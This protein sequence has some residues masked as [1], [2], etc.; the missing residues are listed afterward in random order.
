MLAPVGS[1]LS[2]C[3]IRAPPP[4]EDG[5]RTQ[6]LSAS[7]D[8]DD[9]FPSGG[10][11]P[12]MAS[13]LNKMPLVD[14][15][16]CG[17]DAMVL[18]VRQPSIQSSENEGKIGDHIIAAAPDFVLRKGKKDPSGVKPVAPGGVSETL[19]LPLCPT[20]SIDPALSLPGGIVSDIAQSSPAESSILMLARN[21]RTPTDTELSV[22]LVPEF[23]PVP[24]EDGWKRVQSSSNN[25]NGSIVARNNSLA[26]TAM[27]V[28]LNLIPNLILS[29]PLNHGIAFQN[30]N[31]NMASRPAGRPV[32][33]HTSKRF[34]TRG[35]SLTAADLPANNKKQLTRKSPRLNPWLLRPAVVPLNPLT[36][37]HLLPPIQVAV[38][39]SGGLHYFKLNSIL[40]V[41]EE[42]IIAAGENVEYDE[43]VT[44]FF[45][46]YGYAEGCSMC[47]ILAIGICTGGVNQRLKEFAS[48]AVNTRA[49]SPK[50]TPAIHSSNGLM[51]DTVQGS[52]PL[53]PQGYAFQSSALLD[54]IVKVT[55]RLLRPV[56]HKPLVV[57]T[58]GR[59]VLSKWKS[60]KRL[61][62]AK[63]ELLL[64][65]TT[66]A[67]MLNSLTSLAELMKNWFK[68]AIESVP[69]K[70]RAQS[71]MMD[72]DNRSRQNLSI[73]DAFARQ[74]HL[75]D[76]SGV[77][78]GQLAPAEAER[79][80]KLTEE[81][82]IHSIYRLVSRTRQL[83]QL[84]GL[85]LRA[86]RAT[87]LPE[88]EWG[89][90]HGLTV[91]QLVQTR[92]GQD[93]IEKMLNNLVTS[94]ADYN[95]GLAEP[96]AEADQLASEFADQC[97]LF[98]SPGSRYAYLGFS[99]G[100]RALVCAEGSVRRLEYTA[101]ATKHFQ[102]A[103][104]HWHS[105]N[106][107]TGRTLNTRSQV[108]YKE[109]SKAAYEGGSPVAKAVSILADLGEADAIVD[110][111]LI[112]AANFETAPL[113]AMVAVEQGQSRAFAWENDL[114]H[115]RQ[116][117]QQESSS[118]LEGAGSTP[119]SPSSR[120]LTMGTS[121]TAKDAITTCWFLI[122]YHLT[123]ILQR[124]ELRKLGE[125]MVSRC[126]SERSE[127]FLH[128]FFSHL[129]QSGNTAT[130]L[131]IASPDVE[132][133]LQR[134]V[135][136]QDLLYKYYCIQKEFTKAGNLSLSRA[137]DDRERLSL[138]DR[139]KW[140]SN[141]IAV[142]SA[143]SP[144]RGGAWANRGGSQIE[145]EARDFLD[146]A[147]LQLRVLQASSEADLSPSEYEQLSSSLMKASDLFH[148]ADEHCHYDICLLVMHTCKENNPP[149]IE[150]LWRQIFCSTIFPCSTRD[151]G[152][153]TF[154]SDYQSDFS[155]D[156]LVTFFDRNSESDDSIPLFEDGNWRMKLET[157]VLS[158]GRELYGKGADF[159]FPV[160]FIYSELESKFARFHVISS[161]LL[162]HLTHVIEGLR[163]VYTEVVSGQENI[164]S[165][166]WPMQILTGVGVRYIEVMDAI[167]I[168]DA[169]EQQ[170]GLLGR[171]EH[172]RLEHLSGIVF[173]LEDWVRTAV[174][175][176]E[177]KQ[178]VRFLTLVRRV[179]E[180]L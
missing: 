80:A 68:Q 130:L 166:A 169:Q 133:W 15:S 5:A 49:Y 73:T 36:L 75:R 111:C 139:I 33:Y 106:L 16:F 45:T 160:Q 12:K 110:V 11:A 53:L 136:D 87:G 7:L 164:M 170:I 167:E 70:L 108:G 47:V 173:L 65:D 9:V 64:D 83:L 82:K 157:K 88:V 89:S 50:L 153:Y 77:T 163:R 152:L 124:P 162:C 175:V 122:F 119:V 121:V 17:G 44:R 126:V 27:T 114:Y 30:P 38:I 116:Q 22:G 8:Q 85:L 20:A 21:S 23:V 154:L 180:S 32:K 24:E 118:A 176:S 48:R 145:T 105:A 90:M 13:T 60:Q 168:V 39:N 37:Q 10:F 107:V 84:F 104:K 74:S 171:G 137:K 178:Q 96:S 43:K 63:L 151:N 1:K 71:N 143:G 148:F 141:A 155:T 172:L 158:L 41:F 94:T 61:T 67:Q 100:R 25:I 149:Y 134:E 81:R 26:S 92:D 2:L 40:S 78:N 99:M 135:Q 19:S 131:Q 101:M 150:N 147:K 52:D 102:K 76:T 129:H 97:Y 14:A 179:S 103:A 93:R 58:E 4:L 138:N 132:R 127:P 42:A 123:L 115:R 142:C 72:I 159:V 177:V 31:H 91:S 35:F 112:T 66:T 54:G 125:G 6:D 62:P 3:H 117:A 174:K 113:M 57:V 29:R 98:F 46:S 79:L 165:R 55:S 51:S 56:W 161:L 69:G 146:I 156:N 34:A 128:A 18:A 95:Y 59:T 86:H 109:I 120:S 144:N 28:A 140:L